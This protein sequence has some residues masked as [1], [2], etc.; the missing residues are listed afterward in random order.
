[1]AIANWCKPF[2][3]GERGASKLQ[4]SS[5]K[6]ASSTTSPLTPSTVPSLEEFW[7]LIS[8]AKRTLKRIVRLIL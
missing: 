7:L 5:L 4:Q 8:R 3:Q 1:V 2:D 6:K